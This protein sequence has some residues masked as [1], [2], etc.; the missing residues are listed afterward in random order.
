ML[1]QNIT[2][3]V[4]SLLK[5]D[6]QTSFSYN[7]SLL[8]L[9]SLNEFPR[10]KNAERALDQLEK[11]K[12]SYNQKASKNISTLYATPYETRLG[13]ILV[14]A[15]NYMD[16]GLSISAVELFEQVGLYEECI[17]GLIARSFKEKALELAN[18]LIKEKGKNP[19]LLC[20][21]GD[22]QKGKEVENYE[23]A[24]ELSKGTCARAQRALGWHYFTKND[25]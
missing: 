5:Y 9:R 11:L 2:A 20:M 12:V 8:L 7:F 18:K 19:R 17:D 25:F 22:I 23:E 14:M 24:W 3:G 15:E 1:L 16:I 6:V 13:F 10:I 21:L 4:Q